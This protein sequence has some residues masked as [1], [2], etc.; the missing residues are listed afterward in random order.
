MIT[1]LSCNVQKSKTFAFEFIFT[2]E[3]M[4]SH[5]TFPAEVIL[6][7]KGCIPIKWKPKGC[8]H[9]LVWLCFVSILLPF[10][11]LSFLIL[12]PSNRE[13]GKDLN[14]KESN[15]AIELLT[16]GPTVPLGILQ[17]RCRSDDTS[18]FLLQLPGRP[19]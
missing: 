9:P 2:P 7:H 8:Q 3:L 11:V 13:L 16:P 5:A 4:A 6:M 15:L 19:R 14:L 18:V 10:S 17:A 1:L 12:S